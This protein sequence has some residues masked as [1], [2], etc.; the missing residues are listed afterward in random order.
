MIVS[1]YG[2]TNCKYDGDMT[3]D[4]KIEAKDMFWDKLEGSNTVVLTIVLVIMGDYNNRVSN[5]I[6]CTSTEYT[7]G[8]GCHR[9]ITR[10]TVF[11]GRLRSLIPEPKTE[12]GN[13]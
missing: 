13:K 9:Y 11:L 8:S 10:S 2:P 4:E 1:V 6:E 12:I 5:I 3:G 7:T